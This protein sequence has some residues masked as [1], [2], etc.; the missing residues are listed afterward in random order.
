MACAGRD[1][2]RAIAGKLV[3]HLDSRFYLYGY[4]T[5]EVQLPEI[6]KVKDE[7]H[8]GPVLVT[9]KEKRPPVAVSLGPHLEGLACPRADPSDSRSIR[10]GLKYRMGREPPT[11]SSKHAMG[12]EKFVAAWIVEH[13]TPIPAG[14]LV[15]GPEY[16]ASINQSLLR[17]KELL[18]EHLSMEG[19][20]V[21]AGE[22]RESRFIDTECHCFCKAESYPTYKYPR[23]ISARVDRSKIAFGKYFKLIE[24]ELYEGKIIPSNH[25]YEFIKHVP[26]PDRPAYIEEHVGKIGED[27]KYAATDYTSFEAHFTPEVMMRVE[28]QLYKY[29]TQFLD[30]YDLF[31]Q[32]LD[33]VLAGTNH[34]IFK[35]FEALITGTRMSGETNTSLG[36]GFFNLMAFYYACHVSGATN[37]SG[38]VE[39]DD[40]LFSFEGSAPTELDFEEMGLIIKLEYHPDLNSASF[41]GIIYDSED[42]A[43]I[44]EPFEVL[45]DTPYT[46]TFY[47]TARSDTLKLLL[48]AKA[49][50]LAYQ[51]PRCPILSHYADYLLRMTADVDDDR[52]KKLLEG[53]ETNWWEKNTLARA[54][55]KAAKTEIG[56]NSRN[57]MFTKFGVSPTDQ[58]YIEKY[59][60]NKKDLSPVNDPLI[61]LMIADKN[62]VWVEYY[63]NYS[64]RM[65]RHDKNLYYP[66]L[67]VPEIRSQS[68][69]P[70]RSEWAK[71]KGSVNAVAKIGRETRPVFDFAAP[72]VDIKPLIADFSLWEEFLNP[73]P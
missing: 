46:T 64:V 41:C 33:G 22:R 2:Q 18:K 7:L 38:V 40:G 73:V 3:N 36:N 68:E 70:T 65:S 44:V 31:V 50:S 5:S 14:T 26:V 13:L 16:I 10:D 49:Y 25:R 6:P 60:D 28:F 24:A 61:L 43:N 51:Y 4:R 19:R 48:K 12:F 69:E 53:K 72:E 54:I 55:G 66:P 1:Q 42:K 20:S 63:N 21:L 30:G 56:E 37:V 9:H 71:V 27:V 8:V 67:Y 58:L 52:V 15:L 45:V 32:L 62:P 39:G 17:K 59:F 34:M 47:A 23:V 29:M 11:C 35:E 57:L